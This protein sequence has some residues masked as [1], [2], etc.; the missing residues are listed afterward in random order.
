MS[1]LAAVLLLVACPTDLNDCRETGAPQPIYESAM[2]CR[3]DMLAQPS[4]SLDGKQLLG[5]CVAVDP[6]MIAEDAEIVWD[7]SGKRELSA[8]V[9]LIDEPVATEES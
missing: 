7:V 6:A 4:I 8:E 2:A 1:Q 9:R 3:R 5:T